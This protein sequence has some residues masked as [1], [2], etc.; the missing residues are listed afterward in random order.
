METTVAFRILNKAVSLIVILAVSEQEL[1]GRGLA[2]AAPVLPGEHWVFESAGVPGG[3]TSPFPAAFFVRQGLL[4]GGHVLRAIRSFLDS[5]VSVIDGLLNGFL[6]RSRVLLN[7]E[8]IAVPAVVIERL[9][10]FCSI[11]EKVASIS[12]SRRGVAVI[13]LAV[14]LDVIPVVNAVPER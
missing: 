5:V 13:P 8:I 7:F 3:V 4:G 10:L 1:S 6:R 9:E 14:D 2:C 12:F 11:H